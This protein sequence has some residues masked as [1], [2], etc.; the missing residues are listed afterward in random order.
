MIR[1]LIIEDEQLAANKLERL[2]QK[3]PQRNEVVQRLTSIGEAL[4]YLTVHLNEID[5]IF[6]DIHLGDGNCFELFEHLN[7]EA[8][9]IFTTA[10]DQYAIQAF[11]QNSIAYL[12]KPVTM[13]GLIKAVEKYEKFY[14]TKPQSSA[15]D[16]EQLAALFQ[17]KVKVKERFLVSVGSKI[18]TVE[19][20]NIAY[21]FSEQGNTFLIT[22]NGNIY[23]INYTLE[24][25]MPTLD[26]D[27]FYRV[28]RKIIVHIQAIQEAY[29]FSKSKLRLELYPKA[30]FEVFVPL[31]RVV[32]F[33]KWMG[34]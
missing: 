19:T 29:Q 7:I 22:T 16:Y 2:L 25:L 21:F 11:Q 13:E 18:R 10:Y 1:T 3:L 14:H 20:A 4:P 26:D 34:R 32:A 31:D 33:K 15:V 5:L 12:L 8:P 24:K 9:I 27:I 6:M 23:D 17:A 28:N 30:K